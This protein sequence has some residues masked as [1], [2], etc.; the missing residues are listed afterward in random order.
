ME[1]NKGMAQVS[2]EDLREFKAWKEEKERKERKQ[3]ELSAYEEMVD[4]AIKERIG[5]FVRLSKDLA[6][7]KTDTFE[8]FSSLI[9]MKREICKVKAG[10]QRSHTFTSKDGKSRITLGV[11][12]SDNFTDLAETGIEKVKEYIQSLSKDAESQAL[13]SMVLDLLSKDQKGNLNANKVIQLRKV[14]KDTGNKDFI[15]AVALIERAYCPQV[16]KTYVRAEM[17]GENEVGADPL[18]CHRG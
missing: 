3:K 17:R 14:A 10:G 9:D 18:V 13:V 15:E 4:N 6:K 16:S 5:V 12:V 11:T 2:Q 7:I 1:E 8:T